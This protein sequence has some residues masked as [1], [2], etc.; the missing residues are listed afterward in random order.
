M[1]LPG[2]SMNES[3]SLSRICFF[4][5]FLLIA[6]LQPDR[7]ASQGTNYTEGSGLLGVGVI[8]A[9]N[10]HHDKDIGTAGEIQQVPSIG[11][12]FL[13]LTCI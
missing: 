4:L 3:H 13:D 9:T 1:S 5:H 7:E 12:V 2:C 10:S 6:Y 11:V 8:A